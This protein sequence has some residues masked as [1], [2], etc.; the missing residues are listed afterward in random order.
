MTALW[1]EIH[2][3]EYSLKKITVLIIVLLAMLLSACDSVDLGSPESAAESFYDALE[4][5]D[6]DRVKEAMCADAHDFAN[7]LTL[8]VEEIEYDFQ[9]DF[10]EEKEDD[11]TFVAIFGHMNTRLTSDERDTELKFSSRGDHPLLRVRLVKDGDDWKVCP[12][13]GERLLPSNLPE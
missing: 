3:E 4:D 9:I 11:S 13:P 6:R 7:L 12:E 5:Y 2:L 8:P 1:H 10:V